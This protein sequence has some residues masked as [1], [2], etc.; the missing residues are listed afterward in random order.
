MYVNSM[1]SV[2]NIWL[3]NELVLNIE[4][5]ILERTCADCKLF[6]FHFCHF[7]MGQAETIPDASLREEAIQ[8]VRDELKARDPEF[9]DEMNRLPETLDKL[10]ILLAMQRIFWNE[11]SPT[12]RENVTERID[13]FREALN[14]YIVVAFASDEM[15]YNLPA[16]YA[17]EFIAFGVRYLIFK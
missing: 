1:H 16:T 8:R 7:T 2:F 17:W 15:Y 13:E 12:T 11:I 4:F 9:K 5:P 10:K 14:G 3:S 6:Y